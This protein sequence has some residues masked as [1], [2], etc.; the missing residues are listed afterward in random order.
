MPSL[1]IGNGI[2]GLP[3][4]VGAA[5][6]VFLLSALPAARAD[7]GSVSGVRAVATENETAS[8]AALSVLDA[9]GNAVDAAVT[10]ALAA[11]VA[12]PSSSG[13]G[14]GG[15]ALV[16]DA[17]RGEVTALDFRETAPA[18]I[19][20]AAF[21]RRPLPPSERGKLAGTPG[22]PAGLWELH[23]RFGRKRWAE[24]VAPAARIARDGY[25]V[26]A[27]LARAA[28]SMAA[29]LSADAPLSSLY[30]PGGHPVSAQ[31]RL[32]NRLLASTLQRLSQEGARAV[33]EG[34]IASE[35]AALSRSAGG[36]LTTE[37]FARYRTVERPPLQV[38]WE[39]YRVFTM[40]PPSAGGLL[41]A[42][43]LGTFTAA[44]LRALGQGSGA[45]QHAVAEAMRAALADR[46][47]HVGD[48]D[49]VRVD[50][51]AL[52]DPKRLAERRRSISP[53]KTRP[54]SRI[55]QEDHGTHHLVTADADGNVVA[56]TTTVN[57]AFGS[58][59]SGPTTGVVL[60]DQ[61]DDFTP[62]RLSA[63]LGVASPPN[64][65]RPGARPV[66]SMTPTL[67]VR[68]GAVV[69]ALGGS[70]GMT[71]APNVTQVLLSSLV[72]GASPARAVEAPRFGVPFLGSTLTLDARVPAELRADLE[73]RGETVSTERFSGHAVQLIAIDKGRKVPASD[74]RKFG[75]ALAH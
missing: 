2:S 56:L 38:S 60:N 68:D 20:I 14:G 55:V 27:H 37:D 47:L 9:G 29:Q 6:A 64:R 31:V 51:S 21:E 39:G 5:A 19:D 4:L 1:R 52:L 48:P 12:A 50:V 57:N 70:G 49:K 63:G 74:P 11:G 67:V 72:F 59:L 45:Y 35:L 43:V 24:V 73:H 65:P 66:S 42:E 23:R 8:R 54:I 71:I 10:A 18:G 32:K 33:Y 34:P 26:S 30:L 75:S 44:E 61:L 13:L 7:R 69:V 28:S 46:A 25:P 17:K 22:E 53:D 40:G 36:A 41:L 58:L 3:A 15:F 62:Q 16:F